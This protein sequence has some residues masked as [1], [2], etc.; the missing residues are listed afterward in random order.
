MQTRNTQQRQLL[1]DLLN[2]N[3]SHPTADE[4]YAL[5]PSISRGTVYRNLNLLA[6]SGEISRLPMPSGPDHY[7][8]VTEAHHHFLCRQCGRVM[9]TG[10]H[11]RDMMP[12]KLPALSGCKIETCSLVFSGL[13]PACNGLADNK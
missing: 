9:D 4:M 3:S 11:C 2:V 6:E 12:L 7:E 10:I 13:C 8:S 5:A 1:R